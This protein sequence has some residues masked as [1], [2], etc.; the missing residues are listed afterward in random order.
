MEGK[1]TT[2]GVDP[3]PRNNV[4]LADSYR[5][6][7]QEEGIPAEVYMRNYAVIG[8]HDIGLHAFYGQYGV[9]PGDL[10]I[11]DLA[12][13]TLED[14][15]KRGRVKALTDRHDRKKILEKED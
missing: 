12:K 10:Q 8:S 13:L 3:E 7:A 4:V 5:M 15:L 14:I 9:L 11:D 1:N 2:P 6:A